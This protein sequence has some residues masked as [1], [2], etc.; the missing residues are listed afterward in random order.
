M[1]GWPRRAAAMLVH[2]A[3]RSRYSEAF[4]RAA[5]AWGATP[6]GTRQASS[7]IVTSRTKK[8][9]FSMSQCSRH[10]PVRRRR[11]GV[12]TLTIQAGDAADAAGHT[13]ELP[14][15]GGGHPATRLTHRSAAVC[16]F[17]TW[18]VTSRNMPVSLQTR[19]CPLCVTN[20]PLFQRS[21]RSHTTSRQLGRRWGKGRLSLV[22]P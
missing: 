17:V 9:R 1:A 3:A 18:C 15:F 22:D 12:G 7:P 4:R 16:C 20:S 5:G 8:S 10:R 13:L 11:M 2:L 21:F 14:W 6:L 19:P